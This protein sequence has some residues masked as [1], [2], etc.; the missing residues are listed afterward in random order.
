MQVL[1]SQLLF[2]LILGSGR[3]ARIYKFLSKTFWPI[4]NQSQS[5]SQSFP[6]SPARCKG[7]S[8]HSILTLETQR[9]PTQLGKK[10]PS[11]ILTTS[12]RQLRAWTLSCPCFMTTKLWATNFSHALNSMPSS[13]HLG[14]LTERLLAWLASI[15][16][17]WKPDGK[18]VLQPL[19]FC[20][21]DC[22]NKNTSRFSYH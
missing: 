4:W 14:P 7:W 21:P 3:P 1:K 19:F 15:P 16:L 20:V 11:L 12:H 5:K 17:T 10:C 2:R 22:N 18:K 9:L 8:Y 13:S 6:T